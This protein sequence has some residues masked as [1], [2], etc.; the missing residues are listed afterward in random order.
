MSDLNV[1]F[2]KIKQRDPNQPEFHQALAVYNLF[3]QK[4]PNT[5]NKHC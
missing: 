4:I 5:H 3:W 1:L 2:Q